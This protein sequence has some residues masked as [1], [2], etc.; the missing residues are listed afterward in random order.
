ARGPRTGDR[1][2]PLRA[3][4]FAALECRV[5]NAMN[6]G[7]ATYFLADVVHVRE[8][9]PGEVMTSE[10]FRANL[11][12]DRL[13]RYETLL[14][15]AQEKLLAMDTGI[16]RTPWPGPTASVGSAG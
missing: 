8:G 15:E 4:C 10:Y 14:V 11:P 2:V 3:A 5:V 13:R 1:G 12:E 9:R 6:A 7:A 16:D